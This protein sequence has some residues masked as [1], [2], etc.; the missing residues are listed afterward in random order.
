MDILKPN[1]RG[2]CLYCQT[3]VKFEIAENNP[4]LTSIRGH[5]DKFDI[6]FAECPECRRLIIS[7]TKLTKKEK[8]GW[9][10]TDEK[11]VWPQSSGRIPAPSEVPSHI[12]KDYDESALVLPFSSKASAALSRRCLQTVLREA[13]KATSKDLTKQI[14]EVL[15]NLPSFIA[16]NLDAVRHIGNFAAHEQKSK[17][18][19][20]ILDVEDGE[21]EWNLE[22]LDSLFDFYYVK[23]EQEKKKRAKL[24]AKLKEAGKPPIKKP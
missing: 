6:H 15:K 5:K 9:E 11:I 8:G 1:L 22:V 21:A 24:D 17:T 16:D 3:V 2:K 10:T 4:A 14:D 12:A 23:P 13:G 7:I 20:E 19:G 18:T